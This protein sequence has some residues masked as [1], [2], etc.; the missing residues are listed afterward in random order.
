[1]RKAIGSIALHLAKVSRAYFLGPV[2][3]LSPPSLVLLNVH[4]QYKYTCLF[5]KS[6]HP[7]LDPLI[8]R[9]LSLLEFGSSA[10]YDLSE[11]CSGVSL[12]LHS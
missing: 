12:R 1:M 4:L 3:H 9:A 11:T 5:H 2:I 10:V 6:L 8:A 7:C